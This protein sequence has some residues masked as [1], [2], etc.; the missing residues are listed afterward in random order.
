MATGNLSSQ[1]VHL[2]SLDLEVSGVTASLNKVKQET[3]ATAAEIRKIMQDAFT[4]ETGSGTASE[5]TIEKSAKAS[6]TAFESL[7]LAYKQF[8]STVTG[9]NLSS[10]QI[11][12]L[13]SYAQ[14]ASKEVEKLSQSVISSGKAT[15]KEQETLAQYNSLLKELKGSFADAKTAANKFG[16]GLTLGQTV[17]Q[18]QSVLKSVNSLE[19]SY[20]SFLNKLA[21]TKVSDEALGTMPLNIKYTID[22]IKQLSAEIS[23]N[24]KITQNQSDQIAAWQRNLIQAR[25][26]LSQLEAQLKLN[27]EAVKKENVETEKSSVSYEEFS[28]KISSLIAQYSSFQ[29]QLSSSKLT[30][31][32]LGNIP[33]QTESAR[34]QLEKLRG[35]I[36]STEKVTQDQTKAFSDLSETLSKLKT[37]FNDANTYANRTGEGF[38]DLEDKAKTSS[39]VITDFVNKLS[40]KLKWMAAYQLIILVRQAFSDLISTIKETE[41]A[42]VQL[43]RVLNE[44]IESSA[45]SDELYRIAEQYG[46][47]FEN[48]Q[49]TAVLFAQTGQDWQDVIKST[50]ATMLALNTAELDVN[51][52][53]SGL[54]AVMAQFGLE[55]SDLEVVIDKI[56]KTADNFAVTSESI[57]AALQRAGGTA[58]AYNMTL[59]Q[60]VGIITA[61]AEATGRSGEALGTALN[62]LITFS[63]KASSLEKF[64]DYLGL[65]VTEGYNILD[66]WTMLS[67]KINDSGD[68][69][70]KMMAGS[71]EFAGLFNEDMATAIGLTDEYNAAM[72]N[73]QD[74]YSTVGTYRQNYFIA[75]LNN[76]QTAIEAINGMTDAEG[77]S[78]EENKKYMET[79]TSQYNQLVIAAKELA[80]QFGEM[81]FLDFLK[82]L[83]NIG[84]ETLTVSKNFGG[85]YTILSAITTL[86]VVSKWEK[87][88]KVFSGFSGNIVTLSRNLSAF[89]SLLWE[90]KSLTATLS[91]TTV[92]LQ[93]SMAGIAG[94]IGASVTVIIAITSAIK[95]WNE[96]MKEARQEAIEL[97]KTST[98]EAKNLFNAYQDFIEAQTQGGEKLTEATEALLQSLGYES[99]DIPILEERYGS[100]SKAIEEL[101]EQKYELLKVNALLA[102]QAAE[103]AIQDVGG[104]DF[105]LYGT[106]QADQRAYNILSSGK[107]AGIETSEI[108]NGMTAY[109]NL[110]FLN[111]ENYEEA[112]KY[113]TQ[114]K[115]ALDDL[116]GS[117]D[118]NEKAS[119]DI[120][121][122]LVKQIDAIDEA[123]NAYEQAAED[124]ELYGDNQQE[125]MENMANAA[126]ESQDAI[127]GLAESN[128]LSLEQLQE[129]LDS[130]SESYE[131][132]SGK[133]DEFQ[134]AYSTL[135]DVISE[136]NETGIMSA[137]MLQSL[138]ELEPEY[139]NLLDISSN[140]ITIKGDA[141]NNLVASQDVYL[142][143]LAAL[144]IE[145]YATQLQADALAASNQGLT[146][147]EYEAANGASL[148]GGEVY[149][150]A[151]QFLNGEITAN[152]FAQGLSN[153]SGMAS[154][155]TQDLQYLQQQV[156]SY[157]SSLSG[158]LNF[159][160]GTSRGIQRYY[161][162]KTTTSS[163]GKNAALE[164]EKEQLQ[165]QID[166]WEKKKEEVEEYYD[167]QIEALKEVQDSNDRIN[168]Q[169][170]YYNDRQEIITNLEQAQ[171]RSGV[172][173][174][175]KEMEYQ[176]ELIDLEKDWQDQLEDW[177]IEDQ[178]D[179]LETLKEKSVDEISAVIESLQ[180]KV[181]ELSKSTATSVA[182]GVSSG[183]SYASSA[184]NSFV[185]NVSDLSDQQAEKAKEKAT[186]TAETTLETYKTALL[187][188]LEAEFIELLGSI[189]KQSIEQAAETAKS[190]LEQYRN[191]LI[192]PLQKEMQN[193]IRNGMQYSYDFL[194]S[195]VPYGNAK[196]TQ[197]SSTNN[198]NMYANIGSTSAAN[199]TA[200]A[201]SGLLKFPTNPSSFV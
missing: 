144:R 18:I 176:Q 33:Q 48:V 115:E 6:L 29:K 184:V 145:E 193:A 129:Q 164:A 49:E 138:L 81:G 44:D 53:T 74:V 107:Y 125:A 40:D 15:K 143:Q 186:E 136:Y 139:I 32:A 10:N 8:V 16:E 23:N 154:L 163:S 135:N 46:Q 91:A 50:E 20:S 61:L 82:L 109:Q 12:L 147:S 106:N 55:A 123:I 13:K 113:S 97:G 120:Y 157:A 78:Q 151:M 104:Q 124:V 174:R 59:E 57:V 43:Q 192:S 198:V 31:A 83:T 72:M 149:S 47:T 69:L 162:P 128:S 7:N 9:T 199:S 177:D 188:P 182:S 35:E 89:L 165:D 67:A 119:S 197:L 103:Q 134:S 178:I 195:S 66:I 22:E 77:Y 73:S 19:S 179:Q 5:T 133:I 11:T 152:Q 116:N 58:S 79:L 64:S 25:S 65:D 130:L 2:T 156:S 95:N 142:Q 183:L 159:S 117:M 101:V 150:L 70:A 98:D 166:L 194:S 153:I 24:G 90:T 36:T 75:L 173:Y 168:E 122:S 114:L 196:T 148:M 63:M 1:A 137:D 180:E 111:P 92:G 93:A 41:D 141:T 126:E 170:D 171:A 45:I 160:S 201:L 105:T 68:E 140:S 132:I 27:S 38:K 190:M 52:A 167:A 28:K 21:S 34:S 85:L 99:D 191:N 112:K 42:V 56:N 181:S 51:D 127:D 118:S 185:G 4:S 108:A 26:A 96:Q 80:V 158:L 155:A 87:L 88:S 94:A 39:S 100:L 121:Q 76:I 200:K 54:I 37:S 110:S 161:T 62:S 146:L 189:Q 3:E 30:D 84:K 102:Q 169:L 14:E 60:T 71:E 86:V 175:Q 17:S 187:D 172:E 131:T